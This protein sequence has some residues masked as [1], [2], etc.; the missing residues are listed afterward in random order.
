MF[1]DFIWT[2]SFSECSFNL[3]ELVLSSK[4]WEKSGTAPKTSPFWDVE[5]EKQNKDFSQDDPHPE[6]STSFDFFPQKTYQNQVS[7]K[8]TGAGEDIRTCSPGTYS[9]EQGI[10]TCVPQVSH[11]STVK[12][13]ATTETDHILFARQQ[14]Q[15]TRGSSNFKKVINKF[16]KLSQ[17]LTTA[18]VALMVN[19]GSFEL[20]GPLFQTGLKFRYQLTKDDRVKYFH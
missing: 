19:L 11:N 18:M 8:M 5:A 17:S 10:S 1:Q 7:Y 3:N 2:E 14:L 6:V 4:F 12:I 20:F 13:S 16:S 9:G 15:S